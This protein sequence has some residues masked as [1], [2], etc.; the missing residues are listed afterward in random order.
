MICDQHPGEQAEYFSRFSK[1]LVCQKCVIESHRDQLSECTLIDRDRVKTEMDLC[2]DKLIDHKSLV[3]QAIKEVALLLD[4]DHTLNSSEFMYLL[5][6]V[7]QILPAKAV[8]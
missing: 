7:D 5:S 1:R 8:Q 4:H 2:L 6:Q 3:E